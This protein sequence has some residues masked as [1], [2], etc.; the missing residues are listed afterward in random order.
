MVELRKYQAQFMEEVHTPPQE[1]SSFKN[2]VD[3]LAFTMVELAKTMA[4]MPK[5]EASFKTQIQHVPLKC[6]KEDM[7]LKATSYTQLGLEKEQPKQ[8]ESMSKEE[9]VENYM[10][11][12]ENMATMSFDGQHESSPS[13]LGVKS[14]L[15]LS[16]SLE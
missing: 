16:L 1:E 10:K 4:K 7:T 9:L 8:E 6:L 12:Q 11:E 13:T 3:E 2:G 15:R 14:A 5:E